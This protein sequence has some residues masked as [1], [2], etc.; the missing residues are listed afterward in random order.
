MSIKRTIKIQ[1]AQKCILSI[2]NARIYT[3]IHEVIS[4]EK[5]KREIFRYV[6]AALIVILLLSGHLGVISFFFF[7]KQKKKK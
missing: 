5:P 1:Q 2:S 3:I 6:Q 7:N 4:A